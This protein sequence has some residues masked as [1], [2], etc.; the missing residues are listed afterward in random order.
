MKKDNKIKKNSRTNITKTKK[1]KEVI[2]EITKG[3]VYKIEDFVL[4]QFA[5]LEDLSPKYASQM[6]MTNIMERLN[7][8]MS[9]IDPDEYYKSFNRAFKAARQNNWIKKDKTL[10]KEG[11]KRLESI[12]PSYHKPKSWDSDWYLVIFDIPEQ[13]KGIREMFR[14]RIKKLGFGQ[15]QRSVWIS[16]YN[17]L[18]NVQDIIKQYYLYQQ[19]ILSQTSKIGQQDPRSL[20][21][22]VWR[23]DKI[24]KA[25]AN[26]IYHWRD[27]QKEDI[28][29]FKV[30]VEY[31]SILEKD[32]QLPEE[33]LPDYWYGEDAYRIFQKLIT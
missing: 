7:L 24:N 16:P 30:R 23:L 28:F 10:T 15:L 8:R 19:V 20:A 14:E 2:F 22:R 6:S 32:P 21:N 12:I 4:F 13:K 11:K 33:L 9:G 18:P 5:L 31:W 26:F 25:Y 27:C 3:L 29:P 17:F 1:I